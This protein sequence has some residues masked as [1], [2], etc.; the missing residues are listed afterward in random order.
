[1]TPEF[2]IVMPL[3]S[4]I[5][6]THGRG[7]LLPLIY[8]CV[9]SQEWPHFEWLVDDDSPLP[10]AFMQTLAD[11]R[12]RYFYHR[13]RLSVGAKRNA[14]VERASG[15][16]I[17][18]FDDDDYYSPHYISQMITFLTARHADFV[19]LSGFFLY[20]RPY[21][22][23]AY[24]DLMITTGLHFVWSARPE[25]AVV[26]TPQNNQN[27]AGNHLGY[28][29]SY[30][31]RRRVWERVQFPDVSWNEDGPFIAAA[32]DTGEVVCLPDTS[33]LTLH[34]L[35]EENSSRCFPQYVLPQ[36]VMDSMF[37][38]ITSYWQSLCIS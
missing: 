21:G 1:M 5:T 13:D 16:Y 38:H 23:L 19:K 12:V 36:F 15:D 33:G 37:P 20:S 10:S 2:S 7:W 4:I 22:Q 17:V 18:H 11:P 25:E 34:I 29:F 26:L 35:H 27:F 30:V 32:Q 6:P 9:K 28:G 31:Y 3:V 8:S 14:L 24:W